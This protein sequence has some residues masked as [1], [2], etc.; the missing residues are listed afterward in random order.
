MSVDFVVIDDNNVTF[1]ENEIETAD[2]T[3]IP[4]KTGSYKLCHTAPSVVVC[5]FFLADH[6]FYVFGAFSLLFFLRLHKGR[7][8]I[9]Y[10]VPI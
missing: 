6:F 1:E 4:S 2:K 10:R 9:R 8:K 7:R 3:A 5:K